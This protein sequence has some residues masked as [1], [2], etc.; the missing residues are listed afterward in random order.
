MD[1]NPIIAVNYVIDGK[2][3]VYHTDGK[4][5]RGPSAPQTGDIFPLEMGFNLGISYLTMIN[6]DHVGNVFYQPII[7]HKFSCLKDLKEGIA[8]FILEF[9]DMYQSVIQ[10]VPFAKVDPLYAAFHFT[11]PTIQDLEKII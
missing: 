5:L 1:N 3:Q 8:D 9:R 2:P 11:Y 4:T 6:P 7:I 10:S